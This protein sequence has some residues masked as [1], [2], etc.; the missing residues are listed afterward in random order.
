MTTIRVARRHRFTSIDRRTIRDKRLSFKARGVLV[1]LLDKPDDWHTSVELLAAESPEGAFSVRSACKELEQFGYLRRVRRHEG[2]R[3][4]V[5]WL[6][7]EVPP[8][9]NDEV[10]QGAETAHCEPSSQGAETA[11]RQGAETAHCPPVIQGAETAQLRTTEEP[12]LKN[13]GLKPLTPSL[14]DSSATTGGTPA[15][16]PRRVAYSPAFEQF[17]SLYPPMRRQGKGKAAAAFTKALRI[18]SE[19]ALMEAVTRFANDPNLPIDEPVKIPHASTWLNESRW[20]DGPLP[21]RGRQQ[22]RHDRGQGFARMALEMNGA[23]NGLNGSTH[24]ST[25]SLER[26]VDDAQ[27]GRGPAHHAG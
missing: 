2:G 9:A 13:E 3:Y 27:D 4:V 26:S 16:L 11:H 17:W 14:L 24:Q 5:E 18:I 25:R 8:D 23:P 15:A 19:P 10:I 20:D 21:A 1:W 22:V 12:L 6:L 7:H